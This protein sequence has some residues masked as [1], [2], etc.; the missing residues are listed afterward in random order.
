MAEEN[1][2]RQ[3]M[4]TPLDEAPFTMNT[5]QMLIN[6]PTVPARYR[7]SQTGVQDMYAAYLVGKELN[8]GPMEAINSLY[9][10]N[11]QVSMLGRLMCAQ[12]WRHG[13]GIK[14]VVKDKSVTAV[15]YRRDPETR[16]LYE[17][18][19]WTFT[20][21]DAKKAYLDE[22]GTYEA[23]PKLMW[24]WRAISALSRIYFADC[25]SGVGYVPEEV[26]I[27]DAP[28]EPLPDNVMV[29]VDQE[30]GSSE[31]I[32]AEELEG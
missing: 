10:V 24:A 23:Y 19:E 29:V 13:H 7:E 1:A 22:K 31:I 4:E 15:A 26:G 30:D 2:I 17:A 9:L 28:I 25:I 21:A 12:I 18:G 5:I 11:G 20:E 3:K 27:E 16:E 8:I 32:E 6:T 14:V